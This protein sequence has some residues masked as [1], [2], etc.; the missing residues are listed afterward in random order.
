MLE[1][2]TSGF[3]LSLSL[4]PGTVWV[5]R[6]G[7][8]G[9]KG[10]VVAACLGFGLSQFIWLCVSVPGLMMMLVNLHFAVTGMYWFASLN[11]AYMGFKFLGTARAKQLDDVP[12]PQ[13]SW[14]IFRGAFVQSLAMPMRLPIAMALILATGTFVNNPPVFESLPGI[15]FGTLLGTVWWWGQLGVLAV[16]FA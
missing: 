4:F 7:V 8:V 3:I 5:A 10:Q 11:L 9:R 15:L 1:G 13:S 14:Q 6:L 12:V 16:L 2:I